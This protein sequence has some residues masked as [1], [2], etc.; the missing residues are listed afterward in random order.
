MP[1]TIL[2]SIMFV[3]EPRTDETTGA[4]KS[5]AVVPAVIAVFAVVVLVILGIFAYLKCTKRRPFHKKP[6]HGMSVRYDSGR[7][8]QSENCK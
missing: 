1:V 5:S 8:D 2:G 7:S 4:P 3:P 6:G